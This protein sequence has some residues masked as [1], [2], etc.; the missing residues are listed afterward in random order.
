MKRALLGLALL[1]TLASASEKMEEQ[2]KYVFQN[3]NSTYV[4]IL[5]FEHKIQK[6]QKKCNVVTSVQKVKIM[7][8]NATVWQ[9]KIL[10]CEDLKFVTNADEYRQIMTTYQAHL[11]VQFNRI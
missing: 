4:D 7:D 10:G 2:I 9:E 11:F 6:K 5:G 1:A 8:Q 3:S